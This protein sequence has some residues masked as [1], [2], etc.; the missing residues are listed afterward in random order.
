MVMPGLF[1]YDIGTRDEENHAKAQSRKGRKTG[2]K[3]ET[4]KSR[5][6]K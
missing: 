5:T 2:G 4:E 6:E 3:K 1:P